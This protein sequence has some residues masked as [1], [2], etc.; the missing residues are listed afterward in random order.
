MLGAR[1]L[2]WYVEALLR[3]DVIKHHSY[4]LIPISVMSN[5][6]EQLGA[7]NCN[8]MERRFNFGMTRL[9]QIDYFQCTNFLNHIQMF[10]LTLKVC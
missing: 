1:C 8:N 5:C 2:S 3:H 7:G 9:M 6:D 10:V 4:Q